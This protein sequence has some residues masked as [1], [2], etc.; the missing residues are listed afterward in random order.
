MET[1]QLINNRGETIKTF[2]Y[3]D[4]YSSWWKA[5]QKAKKLREKLQNKHKK[6]FG[7]ILNCKSNKSFLKKATQ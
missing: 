5:Q 6:W 7:I 2:R 4:T 1:H 3:L